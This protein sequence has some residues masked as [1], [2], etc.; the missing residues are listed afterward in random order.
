ML[1]LAQLTLEQREFEVHGR[2]YTAVFFS[3]ECYSAT[4]SAAD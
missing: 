3:G 2:P 4:R 1:F